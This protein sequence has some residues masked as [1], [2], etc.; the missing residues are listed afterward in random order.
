[1]RSVRYVVQRLEDTIYE[2][3]LFPPT[4]P[5]PADPSP[6]NP[7][8]HVEGEGTGDGGGRAASGGAP[9]LVDVPALEAARE[10]YAALDAAREAVIKRC[11]QFVLV[12][13]IYRLY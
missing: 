13:F 7:V 11:H 10:A 2:L 6:P 12:V 3:S 4:N 9:A 8:S 1:M 5:S